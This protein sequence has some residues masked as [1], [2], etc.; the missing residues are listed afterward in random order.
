MTD[1]LMT[2]K[3]HHLHNIRTGK[4]KWELRRTKAKIDMFDYPFKVYCCESGSKGSIKAEFDCYYIQAVW[5]T[6]QDVKIAAQMACISEYEVREY[7]GD[8]DFIYAYTVDNVKDYT[9]DRGYKIRNISEFG[10]NRPPQSWC[11]IRG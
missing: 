6:D 10:F 7:M 3:P 5:N 2:I 11:Y 8:K 9:R 1:I 4:K